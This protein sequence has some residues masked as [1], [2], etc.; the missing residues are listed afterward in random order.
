MKP[1][2]QERDDDCYDACVASILG[3]PLSE[4]RDSGVDPSIWE[5]ELSE[6]VSPHGWELDF[7]WRNLISIPTGYAILSYEA[8]NGDR[9]AVLFHN[10]EMI[11]DPAGRSFFGRNAKR[12]MWTIFKRRDQ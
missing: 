11:H 12:M 2:Y 1:V 8:M 7:V 10:G 5:L 9:H 4:V 3:V 6:F